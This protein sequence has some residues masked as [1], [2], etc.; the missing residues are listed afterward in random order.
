MISTQMEADITNWA[1][2]QILH[3]QGQQIQIQFYG[4][5]YQ[6]TGGSFKKMT[7]RHTHTQNKNKMDP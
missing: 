2:K 1:I 3:V 6:S 4:G 7:K 5:H